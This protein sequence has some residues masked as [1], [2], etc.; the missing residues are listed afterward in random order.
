MLTESSR[1]AGTT[2]VRYC[3]AETAEV[4]TEPDFTSAFMVADMFDL[5]FFLVSEQ[6]FLSAHSD[7]RQPGLDSITIGEAQSLF[8]A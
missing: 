1:A 8:L 5:L 3:N 2:D 6:S 7:K 4:L